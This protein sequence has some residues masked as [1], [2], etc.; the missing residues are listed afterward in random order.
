MILSTLNIEILGFLLSSSPILPLV[1]GSSGIDLPELPFY[2]LLPSFP[3]SLKSLFLI[4]LGGK[5]KKKYTTNRYKEVSFLAVW[6]FHCC[7]D[8]L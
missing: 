1:C 8:F 5:K 7:F 6:K 2:L 3:S 4:G